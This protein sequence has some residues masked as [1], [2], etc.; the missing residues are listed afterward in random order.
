M[1][2]SVCPLVSH[3][4]PSYRPGNTKLKRGGGNT[5]LIGSTSEEKRQSLA[6]G[7]YT[8]QEVTPWVHFCVIKPVSA[9]QEPPDTAAPST[10]PVLEEAA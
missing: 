7:R 9:E 6:N 5:K 3:G 10:V 1:E 2:S 4:Y 8:R